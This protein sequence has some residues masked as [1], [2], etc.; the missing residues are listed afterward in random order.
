MFFLP[1]F[2]MAVFSHLYCVEDRLNTTPEG[3]LVSIL[4]DGFVVE[5][6]E[7]VWIKLHRRTVQ[8]WLSLSTTGY[9]STENSCMQI[10]SAYANITGINGTR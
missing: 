9:P 5:F 7:Y 10:R 6:R 4:Q 3:D 8:P 1:C 2:S